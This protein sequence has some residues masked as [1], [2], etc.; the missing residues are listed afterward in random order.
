MRI[1]R[2][3]SLLLA[4]TSSVFGA[5]NVAV[6]ELSTKPERADEAAKTVFMK[7]ALLYLA[8]KFGLGDYYNLGSESE[9]IKFI[10]AHR[11]T[12]STKPAL[13]I[14][15][16][17]VDTPSAILGDRTPSFKIDMKRHNSSRCFMKSLFEIFPEQFAKA[18]NTSHIY[19]LTE[20][21]K[22]VLTGENQLSGHKQDDLS[23]DFKDFHHKLPQKWSFMVDSISSKQNVIKEL[24]YSLQLVNDKFYISELM[25][26]LKFSSKYTNL[27]EELKILIPAFVVANL[28][29]L[30]SLGSKVGYGARTY[31]VAKAALVGSIETL[32]NTF[33]ITVVAFGPEHK[34][35]GDLK[36][37]NKRSKALNEL[38]SDFSKRESTPDSNC[39][40]D[41]SKCQTS[42]DNCNEH[43]ACTEVR[44]MCWQCLCSPSYNKITS[45]TTKWAGYDCSKKDI[46]AQSQ[47]LLWTSVALL[48][49]LVGSV[50]LLLNI[51]NDS[52]PGVL[53]AAT[54]RKSV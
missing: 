53:E 8:D 42:T 12:E 34:Q 38:F 50:K 19:H 17:G 35:T 47:L 52:L 39:F 5:S 1:V 25:Q 9:P 13:L 46:A 43:G 7:T 2:F 6:Y 31:K 18:S 21:I 15:M 54:S 40:S 29:S 26:L 4:G 33:D 36:D 37:I 45:R 48:V 23:H 41:E 30:F 27:N 11:K 20:E 16:K 28:D 22:Y 49:T 10:E 32:R 3:C 44:S 14:L 24:D 51:G